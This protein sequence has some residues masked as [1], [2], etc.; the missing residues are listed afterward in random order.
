MREKREKGWAVKAMKCNRL[1]DLQ[2]NFAKNTLCAKSAKRGR[3]A[4]RVGSIEKMDFWG[5]GR[6]ISAV[7][8][9]SLNSFQG[10]NL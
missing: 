6:A 10:K 7:S 9:V 8:A 3:M 1:K 4:R 5:G 2:Y